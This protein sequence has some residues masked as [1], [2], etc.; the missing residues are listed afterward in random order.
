[1]M[2]LKTIVL[3][4]AYMVEFLKLRS[5]IMS[6]NIK[7][8]TRQLVQTNLGSL[9]V[10]VGGHGPAILFWPSLMMNGSMWMGQSEHLLAN[11]QVILIDS[12][13]HGESESLKG[14]FTLEQCALCLAQIMD[15]LNVSRACI[16][17]NSWGGM[18]GGVFAAL[19]P[20]RTAGAVLMNCTATPA[21]YKQKVE[22]LAMTK[23]VRL[24]GS[25][26]KAFVGKSVQAFM[27][28]T[29]ELGRPDVVEYVRQT[30]SK[31]N[32]TSVVWAI[33]SVVP[34]RRDQHA[35]LKSI[36]SKVLVVAGEEDR[37]FTVTE[38]RQMADAIPESDFKVLDK[39]GH[40]IALE[41]P[42]RVNQVIDD[43][44]RE[45]DF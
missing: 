21:S 10:Q 25:M 34:F 44:L 36:K 9:S 6:S 38:T 5:L 24:L 19:Y 18:V 8:L 15:E 16:V 40:L 32:P 2:V 1:M 33:D 3:F 14:L 28:P 7:A 17:G 12:P 27:G 11:Y 39:L 29:T 4:K 41:D 23:L 22:Y 42:E 45:I 35:L 43:F 13:G 31:V 37:T 20:H 26:P 30:V